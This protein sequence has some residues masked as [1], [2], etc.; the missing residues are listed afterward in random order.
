MHRPRPS[1]CAPSTLVRLTALALG[2]LAVAL[3]PAPAEATFSLCAIDPETG[4]VGVVVTTR[5][6]FVGRAVPWVEVGVGAVA[7]QSWTVVEYGP[8]GLELLE[9]GLE[10]EEVLDR[11]L[12]DDEGRELRQLG[13]IAMDGDAAAFTGEENTP[14]AGSR[15]GPHYTVQGNLLVGR[16]VIDA[17]ADHFESTAG[18]GMPLAERLIL[19]LQAGQARGGDARWGN[20]QSAALKVA[21]PDDPGRGGDHLSF[22]IQVGEHPTPVAELLRIYRTTARRLGWRSFSEVRGPDVY[23]LKQALHTLG[24]YEPELEE[25][26]E[27]PELDLDPQRGRRD[28]QAF[29]ESLRAY[30]GEAQAFSDAWQ[31]YDETTIEAVDAFREAHD[32]D[33]PGNPRGLVDEAFVE[34]LGR[35]LREAEEAPAEATEP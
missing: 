24:Y 6:P 11:L 15:Q 10:P 12:A 2:L 3:A 30:S 8:R 18:T 22:D 31:V 5:V 34:A 32:L 20:L 35:A 1:R 27:P 25:L 7:T 19:A 26:P 29:E 4:E 21:D 13:V 16:E 23:E 17:V 9:E 14:W 33:H 28:K